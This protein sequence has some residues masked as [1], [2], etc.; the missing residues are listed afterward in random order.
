MQFYKQTIFFVVGL[1]TPLLGINGIR[2]LKILSPP[3]ACVA[4]VSCGESSD[5]TYRFPRI[6]QELGEFRGEVEIKIEPGHTP[7]VQSVPRNVAIPLLPRLKE[8]LDR[9]VKLDMIEPIEDVTEWVSPIVVVPKA[10]KLYRVKQRC[11]ASVFS[12]GDY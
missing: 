9:L 1:K 10:N 5:L 11:H 4:S 2:A 6:F 7:F 3:R 12:Y 8:K